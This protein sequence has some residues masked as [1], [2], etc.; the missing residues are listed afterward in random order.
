MRAQI[1]EMQC[2]DH[3]EESLECQDF[4]VHLVGQGLTFSKP[5]GGQQESQWV[6]GWEGYKG[7]GG[8]VVSSREQMPGPRQLFSAPADYCQ[9][10]TWA[11]SCQAF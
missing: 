5:A 3:T 2:Y 11:W 7:A 1:I 8:G 6:E 9:V 10:G 4:R